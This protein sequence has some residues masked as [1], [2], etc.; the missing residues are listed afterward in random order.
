MARTQPE[1]V[2]LDHAATSWPKSPQVIEAVLEYIQDCGATTGRGG[3][4]SALRADRWLQDART[5]VSRLI[6]AKTASEIAICSSG[7]HALNAGLF[8]ILKAGDHVI[9]TEAEHNSVLRPL[10]QW[11]QQLG[12]SFSVAEIDSQGRASAKSARSLIREETRLIALG[13]GSNVTG[14]VQDLQSW[15]DVALQAGAILLVDASQTLGYIPIDVGTTG[16]GILAAATHK[17]LGGL[18]GTGILYVQ[19]SQQKPFSPLMLGGTGVASEQLDA[20]NTWP[21]CVEVG[22]LNMPGVVSIAVAAKH[23]IETPDLL[24][25][26]KRPFKRL[27]EGL[28]QIP[29]LQIVGFDSSSSTSASELGTERIPVVSVQVEGW[30]VHD[31][32]SILDT[33]FGIEVRAGWHC[34]ALIHRPLGV[35]EAGG[36]LRLSVGHG[37]KSENVDYAVD[38]LQQILG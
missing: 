9:T 2:Y 4:A 7:T 29:Q 13:H 22:N 37:T 15:S 23:L 18:S 27:L 38:A 1:R 20:P 31:L 6:G 21:H 19:Q 30:D 12:I 11:Q 3:Y 35:S 26:W 5:H 14:I 33:S 16:I 34:A 36:T 25:A 17:G 32:A 10:V 24:H 8:G 28:L